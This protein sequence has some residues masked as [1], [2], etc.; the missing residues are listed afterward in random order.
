[1][2]FG[3]SA[4]LW[5]ALSAL[6]STACTSSGADDAG[7]SIEAESG[8]LALLQLERFNDATGLSSRVVIGAKIA[9]YRGLDGDALLRL[10]GVPAVSLERCELGGGL[11]AETPAP[12]AEVELLSIG[13][14]HVRAAEAEVELSP[15]L[16][17]ALATMASGVFY[18]ADTELTAPRAESDEYL[19][20][21][22]GERGVGAFEAVISAP[23]ELT[24]LDVQSSPMEQLEVIDRSGDLVLSWEADDPRDRV[25]IELLSGGS[26]LSCSARDDGHF[27]ITASE[28][29]A[30]E[31]HDNAT[32]VV[33][34]VRSV[35]LEM[36]SVPNAYARVVST[37]SHAVAVR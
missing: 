22:P 32:L 28:L 21:A 18:A 2:R 15:R 19:L 1:M 25:E 31:P 17:P 3:R 23:S 34:R 20:R 7:A 12:E 27:A 8:A 30:L 5:L 37:R 14:L 9:K 6:V 24:V 29:S 4:W 33:R 10:L 35:A 26:V 11:S 13:E 36:Q 16:F